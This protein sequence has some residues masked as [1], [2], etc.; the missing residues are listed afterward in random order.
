MKNKIL[1]LVVLLLSA[2]SYANAYDYG[3]SSNQDPIQNYNNFQDGV[4]EREK[5]IYRKHRK[6]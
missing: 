5:R 1:A 4:R 2:V 6:R 3:Y